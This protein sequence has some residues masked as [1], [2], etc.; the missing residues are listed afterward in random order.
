MGVVQL[1]PVAF[2]DLDGALKQGQ[3]SFLDDHLGCGA[4]GSGEGMR[5]AECLG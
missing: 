3:P 2:S 5:G 1:D 4:R